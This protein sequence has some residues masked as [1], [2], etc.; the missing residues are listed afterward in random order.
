MTARTRTVIFSF[1]FFSF[2][3]YFTFPAMASNE[4]TE[5]G[6]FLLSGVA[7][8]SDYGGALRSFLQN[9]LWYFA[10]IANGLIVQA[11]DVGDLRAFAEETFADSYGS[12]PGGL[13]AVY[14]AAKNEACV[15]FGADVAKY[16]TDA[17]ARSVEAA[18]AAP[19]SDDAGEHAAN[20]LRRLLVCVF[21][22]GDFDVPAFSYTAQF[23]R[24]PDGAI[25]AEPE[26]DARLL[27]ARDGSGEQ[28]GA[29]FAQCHYLANEISRWSG[30]AVRGSFLDFRGSPAADIAAG[31]AENAPEKSAE[32]AAFAFDLASG[33]AAAY[34]GDALPAGAAD[35]LK[36]AMESADGDGYDHAMAGLTE[37]AKILFAD[38][39]REYDPNSGIALALDPDA[40]AE[41]GTAVPAVWI[42]VAALA[43]FAL[44]AVAVL[45]CL[46]KKRSH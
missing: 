17:D 13:L 34:A 38:G 32:L 31:F 1:L 15:V 4:L 10:G 26:P 16:L 33:S 20:G 28:D 39:S 2:L 46:K 22:G 27:I 8:V 19:A 24:D 43:A 11:E 12:A 40:F 35:R 6:T 45:L 7:G 36:S 21:D 42:A 9:E 18:F 30:I 29:K 37:L 41:S 23:L 44:A 25:C 14:S 3:T 5:G